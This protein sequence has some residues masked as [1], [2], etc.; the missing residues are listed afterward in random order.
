MKLI[1]EVEIEEGN[2]SVGE[3][4]IEAVNQLLE[5]RNLAIEIKWDN[6]SLLL[7]E[8]RDKP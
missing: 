4:I 3:D 6:E 5:S 7:F 2:S 8:V 1:D